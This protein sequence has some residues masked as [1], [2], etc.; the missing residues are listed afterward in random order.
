MRHNR[1][2]LKGWAALF[3]AV[4]PFVAA[5]GSPDTNT[6][7]P[8]SSQESYIPA[9]NAAGTTNFLSEGRGWL[10]LVISGAPEGAVVERVVIG[11]PAWQCGVLSGDVIVATDKRL[12][13]GLSLPTIVRLLRQ[14]VGSELELTISRAGQKQFLHLKVKRELVRPSPEGID[15]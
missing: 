6:I 4:T 12:L 14:P 11:G 8:R 10:G 1:H 15:F 9:S 13:A 3:V 7:P 5:L 2:A